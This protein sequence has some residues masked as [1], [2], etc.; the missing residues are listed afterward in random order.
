MNR[1]SVLIVSDDTEFAR[2]VAARWQS[3]GHAAG[4]TIVTSD[5]WRPASSAGYDLSII[6]PTREATRRSILAASSARPGS[7]VVCLAEETDIPALH[8]EYPQLLLVTAGDGWAGTLISLSL[9][10][11][12]RVDAVARAQD[13]ERQALAA[14]RHATLGRYML[15]MRPSVNNALTSVVG[16]ADLLLAGADRLPGDCRD[17]IQAI[18]TTALRLG[19]IMQRFSSLATE[20]RLTE[21][22]S[23]AET[24]RFLNHLVSRT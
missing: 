23:Q 15:E 8:A 7:A 13:A 24:K 18:H 20:M 10:A 1:A 17:Q 5:V 2:T 14:E 16:N 11:L 6:G 12:R 9:E 22:E 4:I 3:E 19:E 21:N